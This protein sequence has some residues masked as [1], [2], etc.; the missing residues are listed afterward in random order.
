MREILTLGAGAALIVG[1][2]SGGLRWLVAP[3]PA[4]TAAELSGWLTA[5]LA[6]LA[7]FTGWLAAKAPVWRKQWVEAT[8][9]TVAGQLSHATEMNAFKEEKIQTQTREIVS[10]RESNDSL[11]KQ[12]H[13]REAEFDQLMDANKR[14]LDLTKALTDRVEAKVDQVNTTLTNTPPPVHVDSKAPE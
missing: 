3:S 11:R 7:G 4:I 5:V 2:L 12:L 9:S 14:L 8:D 6:A 10:L 1:G 13:Y